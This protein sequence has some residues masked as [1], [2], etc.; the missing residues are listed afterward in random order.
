MTLISTHD[1]LVLSSSV[2]RGWDRLTELESASSNVQRTT[3]HASTSELS[4]LSDLYDSKFEKAR[5]NIAILPPGDV[6]VA[7]QLDCQQAVAFG[8][9]GL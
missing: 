4:L 3:C 1:T 5:D 7:F 2:L 9:I 6:G 8:S